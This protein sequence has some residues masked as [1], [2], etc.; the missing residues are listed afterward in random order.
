MGCCSGMIKVQ[1]NKGEV[2]HQHTR[3]RDEFGSLSE[4]V[5][6]DKASGWRVWYCTPK[7]QEFLNAKL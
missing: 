2:C 5:L 4:T 3:G 7:G 1:H 6:A